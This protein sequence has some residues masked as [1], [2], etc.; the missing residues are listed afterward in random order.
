MQMSSDATAANW[1]RSGF[2]RRRKKRKRAEK[3]RAPEKSKSKYADATQRRL[4]R[5]RSMVKEGTDVWMDYYICL[6]FAICYTLRPFG[7]FRHLWPLPAAEEAEAAGCERR[8]RRFW[9]EP[10]VRLW[11]ELCYLL[12]LFHQVPPIALCSQRAEAQQI[13]GYN[14]VCQ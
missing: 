12:T 8:E 10:P 14:C 4:P 11:L 13:S 6:L 3:G 7:R 1:G 9:C 5:V 2:R